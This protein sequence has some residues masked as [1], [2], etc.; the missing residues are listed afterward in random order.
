MPEAE[1]KG[2]AGWHSINYRHPE[3]GYFLGHGADAS[4][5]YWV[6]A[7]VVYS[8]DLDRGIDILRFTP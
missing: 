6:T 2:N 1:E 5:A 3:V 8:I 4:A 7:D